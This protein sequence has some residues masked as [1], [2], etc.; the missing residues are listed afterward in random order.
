MRDAAYGGTFGYRATV[1]QSFERPQG[2]MMALPPFIAEQNTYTLIF[3]GKA[4]A[5]PGLNFRYEHPT[6]AIVVEVKA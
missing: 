3:W 4:T 1:L 5:A 6:P 2:A